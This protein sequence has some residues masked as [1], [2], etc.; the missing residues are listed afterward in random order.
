M[1]KLPRKGR[2]QILERK[3]MNCMCQLK[4]QDLSFQLFSGYKTTA[5][6]LS[7]TWFARPLI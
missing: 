4:H 6:E 3:V 5:V 7:L 1:A 2:E